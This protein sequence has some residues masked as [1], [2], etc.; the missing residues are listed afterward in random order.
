MGTPPTQR[1]QAPTPGTANRLFL[2][3]NLTSMPV[4]HLVMM[5][6]RKSQLEVWGHTAITPWRAG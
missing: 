3:Q 6:A 1:I 4:D 5:P 2:P